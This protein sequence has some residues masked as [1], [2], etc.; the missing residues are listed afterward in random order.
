M[1]AYVAVC[2]FIVGLLAIRALVSSVG[3]P[4]M[5][6]L[7]AEILAGVMLMAL[8][9]LALDALS[10]WLQRGMDGYIRGHNQYI[11]DAALD[12]TQEMETTDND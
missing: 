12:D 11:G 7:M 5:R 6:F 1:L 3:G 10:K 2:V 8:A 9:C 4:A